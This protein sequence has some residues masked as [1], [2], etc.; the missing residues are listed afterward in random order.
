M[1]LP[2]MLSAR[3]TSL[4]V[5]LLATQAHAAGPPEAL[6]GKSVILTWTE[7]RQQRY[8]GEPHFYSVDASHN[9]S[10]YVSTA[11]R[12]F[13]RLTNSTRAGS[14]TAEQV[15]GQSGGAYGTRTTLFDGQTMTV[16]GVAKGGGGARRILIEFDA[17]FASCN[18]RV[19]S[20]F[21]SGKSSVILSMITKKYV[22]T[23]SV[24]TSGASCSVKSGN[25][26][27]GAT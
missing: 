27:A 26:L 14:G 22:E 23:K 10:I 5:M 17:S 8:V 18:A 9:L 6:K 15:P 11:G 7:T 1:E 21:E 24:T 3:P 4:L 19:A 20:G 16:I 25:V 12:T 13:G 2:M